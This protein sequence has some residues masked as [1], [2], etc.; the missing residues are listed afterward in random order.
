M[1]IMSCSCSP[2]QPGVYMLSIDGDQVGML[3]V[4]QAFQEVLALGAEDE[5]ALAGE[6]LARLKKRNYIPDG[7]LDKYRAALLREYK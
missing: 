7:A 1:I 5:E 4:E 2:K 6:L 3:G